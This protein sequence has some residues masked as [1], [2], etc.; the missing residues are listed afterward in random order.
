[1]SRSSRQHLKDSKGS[2]LSQNSQGSESSQNSQKLDGTVPPFDE[3]P[4]GLDV[5]D[6][7]DD[8]EK[9][10]QDAQ[11]QKAQE[12]AAEEAAK[13]AAADEKARLESEAARK[14]LAALLATAESDE[15][16]T[17][18]KYAAKKRKRKEE[19]RVAS[20]LVR[21]QAVSLY[22]WY[23]NQPGVNRATALAQFRTDKDNFL[24]YVTSLRDADESLKNAV[25][26]AR[27]A[28][29][30]KLDTSHTYCE[31]CYNSF[32]TDS[33]NEARVGHCYNCN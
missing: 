32:G 13:K 22:Q 5:K 3:T 17:R 9:A 1:M 12:R 28:Q 30:P 27:L 10:R 16:Y 11:Q 20:S 4:L 18:K 29:K 14:T 21:S 7:L 24:S 19:E 8:A 15:A 23:V 25:A 2:E 26:T 6:M 31:R 33:T